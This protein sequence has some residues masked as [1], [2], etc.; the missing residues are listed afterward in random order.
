M[1]G[2]CLKCVTFQQQTW[3]VI[4]FTRVI[5]MYAMYTWLVF[6]LFNYLYIPAVIPSYFN[7]YSFIACFGYSNKV[8]LLPFIN[9]SFLF[10]KSWLLFHVFPFKWISEWAYQIICKSLVEFWVAMLWICKLN[11]GKI[12][13]LILFTFI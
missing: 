7:Y 13:I 4:F 11:W 5:P 12:L 2:N 1:A 8:I 6:L 9:T 10:P 3:N